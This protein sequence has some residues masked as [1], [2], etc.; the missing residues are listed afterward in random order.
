MNLFE[1]PCCGSYNSDHGNQEV[2][3]LNA[4]VSN[5]ER[6][7]DHSDRVPMPQRC[8]FI[9]RAKE[10]ITGVG[11][12]KYRRTNLSKGATTYEDNT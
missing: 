2:G 5:W 3:T 9:H 1:P 7:G 4:S 12:A 6:L 8:I 11:T 10:R